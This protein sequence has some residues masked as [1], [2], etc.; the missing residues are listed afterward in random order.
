M[1]RNDLDF[2]LN[3]TMSVVLYSNTDC[4]FLLLLLRRRW[5][6]KRSCLTF[7]RDILCIIG[8]QAAGHWQIFLRHRGKTS[9]CEMR[10]CR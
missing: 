2:A 10:R 5:W 8:L 7:G 3:N 6:F 4:R 1:C 9:V